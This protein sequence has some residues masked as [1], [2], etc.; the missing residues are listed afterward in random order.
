MDTLIQ[1][2]H[3]TSKFLESQFGVDIRG[4]NGK[5]ILQE[6]I[7]SIKLDGFGIEDEELHPRRWLQS[8]D[9]EF[10]TSILLVCFCVICAGLASG[11]TQVRVLLCFF[12]TFL[13]HFVSFT[14]IR[15]C[16]RWT[17]LKCP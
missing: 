6:L 5:N 15:V 4:E 8:T 2:F 7:N 16:F 9:N 13:E 3:Y 14:M 10:T 12:P 17:C 11:L 1:E